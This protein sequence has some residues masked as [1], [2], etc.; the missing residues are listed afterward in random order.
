MNVKWV[1]S[2]RIEIDK[3]TY[4]QDYYSVDNRRMLIIGT[5]NY[6]GATQI[7]DAWSV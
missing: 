6:N 3:V 1:S 2:F 5:R 7:V 4:T